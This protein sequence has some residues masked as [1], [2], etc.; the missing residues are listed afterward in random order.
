M[1]DKSEN[2]VF[3]VAYHSTKNALNLPLLGEPRPKTEAVNSSLISAEDESRYDLDSVQ[4]WG[5]LLPGQLGFSRDVNL[6]V[7]FQDFHHVVVLK[8][9]GIIH[10]QVSPPEPGRRKKDIM[11][12]GGSAGQYE[13]GW[14]QCGEMDK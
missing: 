3:T 8:L 11:E 2:I 1:R 4:P 5:M 13:S 9:R 14:N 6:L 12:E 7:V 10:R